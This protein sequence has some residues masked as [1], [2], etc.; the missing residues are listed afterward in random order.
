MV[1]GPF[2]GRESVIAIDE[3]DRQNI[4]AGGLKTSHA[5]KGNRQGNKSVSLGA[6]LNEINSLGRRFVSPATPSAIPKICSEINSL[7]FSAKRLG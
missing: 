7:Q 1:A 3:Q 5:D 2:L 6:F 4:V